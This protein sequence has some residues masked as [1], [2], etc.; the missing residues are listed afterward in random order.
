MPVINIDGVIGWDATPEMI[1]EGLKEADGKDV[2]VEINSP[3]GLISD[4]LA[5]FN[6]L[7][8]YSGRVDTHIVGQA[9]SMATYIA[10]AGVKRTAEKNAVFMIHNGWGLAI[11]DHRE[12]FKYGNHLDSLT[13]IIAKQY[14]SSTGRD[15]E[16]LRGL[17]DD[18][19]F[20]YGDEIQE[21][22][23]VDEVIGEDC[24]SS[25]DESLAV[26]K[27]SISACLNTIST[28]DMIKKDMSAIMNLGLVRVKKSDK[29]LKQEKKSMDLAELKKEHPDIYDEVVLVGNSQERERVNS[30]VAFR[31]KF[32]ELH[33]VIDESVKEGHS[34]TEFNLNM[35]AAISASKELKEAK[36][37]GADVPAG[38]EDETPEMKD[39]EMTHSD[40]LDEVSKIIAAMPGVN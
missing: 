16:E 31:G 17:M 37:E 32:P 9:A 26:A 22:G 40:H 19:T 24:D 3:G 15:V 8:N 23:F 29:N 35:M 33:S 14:S 36:D 7:R 11:G 30:I 10:Q 20:Y 25:K 12:M 39:G 38:N 27:L 2:T 1:R 34:L 6:Q 21:A 28:P 4:G 13:N 5:I 18:E